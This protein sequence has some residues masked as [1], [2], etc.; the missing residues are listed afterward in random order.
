MK[1]AKLARIHTCVLHIFVFAF[2]R[3]SVTLEKPQSGL[4]VFPFFGFVFF[5]F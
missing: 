4:S 5:R 1:R 2:R 3:L